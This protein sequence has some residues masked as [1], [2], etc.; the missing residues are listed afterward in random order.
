MKKV[1]N[2]IFGMMYSASLVTGILFNLSKVIGFSQVIISLLLPIFQRNDFS[3]P[4][5][6]GYRFSK[7]STERE[8]MLALR[9][10]GMIEE[11]RR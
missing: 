10:E 3:M 4:R 2:V 5:G 11:A 8:S 6:S 9:K 7:S 1:E